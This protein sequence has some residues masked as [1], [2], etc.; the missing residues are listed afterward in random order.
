MNKKEGVKLSAKY[1]SEIKCKAIEL[2]KEGHNDAEIGRILNIPPSTIR[3]WRKAAGIQPSKIGKY[4]QKIKDE[5]LNQ[6]KEG[7][8]N[9]EISRSLG[10]HPRT[11]GGWRKASGFPSLK[12]AQYTTEQFN[13][14]IDLIRE[15]NTLAQIHKKTGVGRRKIKQWREEEVRDG[16]PLPELKKG[17]ARNQKYSDEELIELAFLNPGFG[18]QRFV[19][20]LGVTES[21]VFQL[22]DEFTIALPGGQYVLPC[23]DT[24]I[25]IQFDRGNFPS[26]DP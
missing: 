21:F 22:F 11:I 18:F 19:Q 7:K 20:S 4:P 10:I 3:E 13:H 26:V 14:V 25:V 24:G 23:G 1:P 5:A 17:V 16:N 8:T 6:M 9:A 15:G 12:A 2:A